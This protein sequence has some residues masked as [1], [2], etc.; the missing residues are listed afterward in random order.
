MCLL[1]TEQFFQDFLSKSYRNFVKFW[2]LQGSVWTANWYSSLHRTSTVPPTYLLAGA[3]I[4]GTVITGLD[5]IFRGALYC[6]LYLSRKREIPPLPLNQDSLLANQ[7][8]N[9][10]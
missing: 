3:D 5:V 9:L 10:S 4:L 6:G 8:V 1:L 2:P 7:L